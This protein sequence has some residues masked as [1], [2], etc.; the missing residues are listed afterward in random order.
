MERCCNEGPETGFGPTTTFKVS[1]SCLG[2]RLERFKIFVEV[3]SK[4]S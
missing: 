4:L 1:Q 3:Q 2:L